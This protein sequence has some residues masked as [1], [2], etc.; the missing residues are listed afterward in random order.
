[1]ANTKKKKKGK[2]T[3]YHIKGLLSCLP[4]LLCVMLMGAT[5]V[6]ARVRGMSEG[7]CLS[8]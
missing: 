5:R 2:K 4:P 3:N 6:R 7:V 8:C 1:M